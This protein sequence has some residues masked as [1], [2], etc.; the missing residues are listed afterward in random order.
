VGS[1]VKKKG[2][3]LGSRLVPADMYSSVI[4]VLTVAF[5]PVVMF[6]SA[7]GCH[8]SS[9]GLGCVIRGGLVWMGKNRGWDGMGK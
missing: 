6:F 2:I 5:V 4:R 9:D 8:L 7:F 3:C 1:A